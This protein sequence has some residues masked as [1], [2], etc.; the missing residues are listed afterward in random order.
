MNDIF[1]N[2]YFGNSDL[3]DK[4]FSI[5]TGT[6]RCSAASEIAFNLNQRA[7]EIFGSD[8]KKHIGGEPPNYWNNL[9][10]RAEDIALFT[11]KNSGLNETDSL[12]EFQ[13]T[14]DMSTGLYIFLMN[15]I[16]DQGMPDIRMLEQDLLDCKAFF[17]QDFE[18]STYRPR[19]HD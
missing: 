4:Y 13:I 2:A 16:D 15:K 7:Y 6:A 11:L 1:S 19:P 18:N 17:S 8:L 5:A 12:K 9:S 3:E 10:I 14:Y